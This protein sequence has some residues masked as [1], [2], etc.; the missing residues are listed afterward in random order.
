VLPAS[1]VNDAQVLQD[2]KA[3]QIRFF[4][5]AQ[6]LGVLAHP[7]FDRPLHQLGHLLQI[8]AALSQRLDD[9]IDAL[10]PLIRLDQKVGQQNE[11]GHDDRH[12]DVRNPIAIVQ[13]RAPDA[14]HRGGR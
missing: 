9:L 11:Y 4:V 6:V 1:Q 14:A 8:P 5:G 13:E 3:R 12:I 10:R 7:G 2:Q